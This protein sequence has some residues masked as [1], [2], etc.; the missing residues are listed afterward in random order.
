[1]RCSARRG[2]GQV[3]TARE[4]KP[5]DK[6]LVEVEVTW[7][8]ESTVQCSIAADDGYFLPI[9]A[10]RPVPAAGEAATE[11][12]IERAARVLAQLEPGEEWPSNAAL[13]GNPTGTRD[14][15]F[16][17]AMLDQA[18][19]LAR[20]GLLELPTDTEGSN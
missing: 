9:N 2:R 13:G 12:V 10:L 5:G 20:A 15:E 7:T 4:W 14:D 19:D 6:A 18:R 11:D 3:V 8:D 1:G 17:A 16:R